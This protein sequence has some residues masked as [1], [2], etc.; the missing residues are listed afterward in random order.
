[1][2]LCA[3]PALADLTAEE[4]WADWQDV[5]AGFGATLTGDAT[6]S[7]DTLTI[8]GLTLGFDM[9]GVQSSSDYGSIELVEQ[10]DGSVSVVVPQRME[11]LTTTTVEGRDVTQTMQVE[12]GNL[13]TIVT[14][15][16]DARTYDMTSDRMAYVFE[17]LANGETREPVRGEMVFTD[18]SAI[19]TNTE[20]GTSLVTDQTIAA[21][22]LTFN[23]EATGE[24]GFS[25]NYALKDLAGETAGTLD[26]TP[27]D[28]ETIT[29]ASMGIVLGSQIRHGGS[30]FA[31]DVQTPEGTTSFAG[32]AAAGSIGIDLGADT[33]GYTLSSRESEIRAQIASMPIP[34]QA[35]MAEVTTAF[36]LPLGVGGDPKPFAVNLAYRDLAL[37]DALW[38]LFD[39]TGQLP[40]DAATLILDLS[41][42]AV[43]NVD[44]FGGD[45]EAMAG[46]QGPPGELK[47]MELSQLQLT[48]AGAELKGTGSLDFPTPGPIP[49]PVGK[50]NL[51]LDG[52]MALLD[53]IVA[54][55]FVPAEQAAFIKGMSGV[56]ARPVGEDQLESEIE[57]T[58]GGGI[59]ANGLPL[60]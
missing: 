50:V 35:T 51:T 44:I 21:S 31:M 15:D 8:S 32:T 24:E 49:Q 30:E 5:Y 10:S 18:I 60:Q 45:P 22:G 34:L 58:E 46:L 29:L 14:Q 17:D 57:F 23:A 7:G 9:G 12:T 11:V 43:M 13:A 56:V 1:L 59:T 38:G 48:V 42:T 33:L 26:M 6:K 20:D 25:I 3:G 41:G 27:K 37:D 39:P 36:G 53:K 47:S 55:G 54:L 16:G 52:G 4:L 28:L 40:R 2:M 19:Y